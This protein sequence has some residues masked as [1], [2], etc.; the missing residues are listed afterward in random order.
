MKFPS[1]T[2]WLALEE[3]LN[4]CCPWHPLSFSIS[5]YFVMFT[6]L[7]CGLFNTE[8]AGREYSII[9]NQFSANMNLLF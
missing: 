5:E 8:D 7:E 1:T 3:V 6:C 4:E 2:L 9:L